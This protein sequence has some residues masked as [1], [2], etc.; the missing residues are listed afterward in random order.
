MQHLDT[1]TVNVRGFLLTVLN[2]THHGWKYRMYGDQYEALQRPAYDIG[3]KRPGAFVDVGANVGFYVLLAKAYDMSKRIYAVEPS[4]VNMHCLIATIWRNALHGCT[5][6]MAFA[7]DKHGFGTWGREDETC[8]GMHTFDREVPFLVLDE[9]DI[10]QV[11]FAKLDV[12]GHEAQVLRGF[13][14]T[15]K[16]DKPP[17]V[18]EVA[19]WVMAARGSSTAALL[20]VLGEIGYRQFTLFDFAKNAMVQKDSLKACGE[21]FDTLRVHGLD[22]L[23]Q[24]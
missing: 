4:P 20:D 16:R 9:L 12:E 15:L 19:P 18:V 22:M 6:I 14:A 7:Q 11:G 1:S 23:C 13:C 3:L 24:V 21:Y 17:I 8:D 5:P 10:P 2:G